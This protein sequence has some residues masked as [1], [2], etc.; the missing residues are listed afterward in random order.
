LLCWLLQACRC[1]AGHA[2]GRQGSV[3][4]SAAAL[5]LKRQL[6]LQEPL[7]LCAPCCVVFRWNQR[8]Q[9]AQDSSPRCA[10]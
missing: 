10:G 9:P 8:L 5:L 4:G 2:V 6:A 1:P 7:L 3:K